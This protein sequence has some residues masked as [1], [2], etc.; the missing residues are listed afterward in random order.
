MIKAIITTVLLA[1]LSTVS[2][3]EARKRVPT[4]T[5]NNGVVRVQKTGKIY[6]DYA[7]VRDFKRTHPK[8]NDGR[9]YDIDHIIPLSKGG[10]DKPSNMQWMGVEEHRRK[11]SSE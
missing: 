3:S 6:R 9:A 10:P 11:S 1:V 4:Y 8:P 7:A 2:I 5:D